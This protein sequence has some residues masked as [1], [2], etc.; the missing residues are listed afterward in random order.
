M[1]EKV[2]IMYSKFVQ[3]VLFS[4]KNAFFACGRFHFVVFYERQPHHN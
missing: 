3:S 4:Q 1:A 2:F